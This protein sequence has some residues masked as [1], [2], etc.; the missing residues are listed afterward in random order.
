MNGPV[1]GTLL[2]FAAFAA[3]AWGDGLLKSIGTRLSVFEIGFIGLLGACVATFFMRPPEERWRDMF[4]MRH[5]W[6]TQLRAL[7]GIGAGIFGVYAFVTIPFA[8][9]YSLIF[10]APFIVMIAAIA[11][12]KERPNWL[13]WVALAA[14]VIGVLLVVR[15]G[16]RSMELGHLSALGAALCIAATVTI[17][18]RVAITEKKTSIL[19]IPQ[20]Y[21]LACNGALATATFIMPSWQ[22][23]VVMFSAG[24]LGALGQLLL[25]YASRRAP[26]FTIG[27]AQYSQLIWAAL[28]GAVFFHEYPDALALIGLA[29][30]IAAGLITVGA[31]RLEQR[32]AA[33]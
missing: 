8:E 26:A 1:R 28:I 5:P 19:A 10:L 22:E 32:K 13:G 29:V 14:G 16:V 7:T 15:P 33:A 21:A 12:L 20:L 3:M 23:V 17:L 27:Q 2:A 24:L 31:S 9:A 25:L 4:R 6:L 18:R 11:I 30:I